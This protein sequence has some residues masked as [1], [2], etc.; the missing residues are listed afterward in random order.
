MQ[1]QCKP[2]AIELARIAEVQPVLADFIGKVTAIFF[3]FQE[4]SWILLGI[5]WTN[6]PF[7]DKSRKQAKKL[8][9]VSLEN[10]NLFGFSLDLYYL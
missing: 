3:R 6:A 8:S 9:K 1:G 4:K 2:N 5:V 7:M 10:P